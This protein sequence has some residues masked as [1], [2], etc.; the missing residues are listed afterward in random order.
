MKFFNYENLY[1]AARG[2]P[3]KMIELF[4]SGKYP[5]TDWIVNQKAIVEASKVHSSRHVAEYIGLCSLR[6]YAE[7]KQN[8]NTD[9]DLDRLPPWIP[10]EVVTDNPLVAINANKLIFIKES[11]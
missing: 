2:D 4:L 7:F 8:S 6:S 5:G 9:F 1:L 10:M 3:E 11:K